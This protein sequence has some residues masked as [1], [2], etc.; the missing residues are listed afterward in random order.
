[1]LDEGVEADGGRDDQS[2]AAVV[3]EAVVADVEVALRR[4]RRPPA[5]EHLDGVPRALVER[6]AADVDGA[7][8]AK[9]AHH[10][11]RPLVPRK[12]VAGHDDLLQRSDKTRQMS[13]L[14]NQNCIRGKG[15]LGIK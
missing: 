15:K 6:V 12:R 3:Q 1:M 7:G 4:R 8:R 5:R 14:R 11:R 2:E 10:H 9:V 13:R